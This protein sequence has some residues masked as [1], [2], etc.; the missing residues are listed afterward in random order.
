MIPLSVYSSL[1]K[2]GPW[3]KVPRIEKGVRGS[4]H[5]RD[6]HVSHSI[7]DPYVSRRDVAVVITKWVRKC[8]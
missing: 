4:I 6:I 2:P 5:V 1:R 8:Y 3:Q 7:Q